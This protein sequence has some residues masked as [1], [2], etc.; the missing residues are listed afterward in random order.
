[1]VAIGRHSETMEQV[2]IYKALY[3]PEGE[4]YWVRPLNM[5]EEFVE[6]NGEKLP[7]FKLLENL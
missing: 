4:N 3:Q 2:V 1:M 7:R 5:F 6:C